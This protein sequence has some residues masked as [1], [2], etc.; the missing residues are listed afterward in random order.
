MLT[1]FDHTCREIEI[2]R[3]DHVL[4]FDNNQLEYY[5][6]GEYLTV[7]LIEN[8]LE[9]RI[10]SMKATTST[11]SKQRQSMQSILQSDYGYFNIGDNVCNNR[12]RGPEARIKMPTLDEENGT[13]NT[14]NIWGG[15]T[16]LYDTVKI[17][18]NKT[19]TITLENVLDL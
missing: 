5:R 4:K 14:V 11:K 9:E 12:I 19:L 18:Y 8:K 6:P 1:L 15:W 13:H 10:N 7:R 16:N 3:N 17:T 2:S